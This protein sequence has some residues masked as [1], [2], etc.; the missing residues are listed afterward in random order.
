MT[1]ED[2]QNVCLHDLV[3]ELLKHNQNSNY[4]TFIAKLIQSAERG[5]LNI[6][7]DWK[8]DDQEK[9]AKLVFEN[10]GLMRDIRNA[11]GDALAKYQKTNEL[12]IEIERRFQ[13]YEA[14]KTK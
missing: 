4:Q 9:L 13:A 6:G 7:I 2:I 8:I 11:M 12:Y 10:P 14:N 3:N 1:E 5:E